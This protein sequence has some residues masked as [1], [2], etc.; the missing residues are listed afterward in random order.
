[1]LRWIPHFKDKLHATLWESVT[2]WASAPLISA[3]YKQIRAF[4]NARPD[5]RKLRQCDREDPSRHQY[6]SPQD[7]SRFERPMGEH[8]VF[9][10]KCSVY[11]RV[12]ASLVY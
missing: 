1:M 9:Q 10:R 4:G 7:F 12:N 6:C 3:A 5:K 11:K 8:R 2:V